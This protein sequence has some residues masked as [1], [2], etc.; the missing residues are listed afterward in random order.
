MKQER[1]IVDGYNMIGSWPELLRLKNQDKLEEARDLLLA[2]LSNYAG[3]HHI[4]TWVVFDALFVPGISQQY[5]AYNLKVIFT[6][7]GQTADS[8]IEEMMDAM[9]GILYTVTVAT[10]DLAEQR[11]VFQHGALRKSAQELW[12]DVEQTAK[13]VHTGDDNYRP[14][15]YRRRIPWNRRQLNTLQGLLRD[16]SDEEDNT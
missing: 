13:I 1:L 9:V 2:R 6:A 7:E 15:T 16:L 11:M 10:S 14:L 3:F 8:Y 5:D 4:E 12:R